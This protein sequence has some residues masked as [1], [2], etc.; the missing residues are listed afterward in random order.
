VRG[1]ALIFGGVL[2][3]AAGGAGLWFALGRDTEEA[4]PPP[5]TEGLIQE[6]VAAREHVT[7]VLSGRL[8][9]EFFPC[10]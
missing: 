4:G 6:L 8:M 7:L 10:G 1:P 9:A 5:A 2:A 3:A